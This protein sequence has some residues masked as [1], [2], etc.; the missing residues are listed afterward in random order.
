VIA[1][2]WVCFGCAAVPALLYL[3]NSL[4]FREP[5][6]IEGS[7][8][9]PNPQWV[10][11]SPPSPLSPRER[12]SK[13]L[14]LLPQGEGVGGEGKVGVEG[15]V[16]VLIPARNEE[17][18][19][20][21]CVEAVLATQAVEIEVI[22]LDDHSSDRTAEVVRGIAARDPRVRLDSAPPLPDGWSGKQHACFVLSKLARY[23]HFAFLD[24]DVRLK[25]DALARMM[26]FL[27]QSQA[28]LVSGF[29]FQETGSFLEKMLI[30]LINWLLLSFL[31]IFFMRYFR[32]AGFGAGCG[33]LFVSSRSAYQKAGGHQAIKSSRHD[34]LMLPR[35]Y[36]RTGFMTD[37]CDAGSIATCRMYRSFHTV[38]FG[39]AKNAREG[40]A[41]TRQIGFWTM[42]LTCGQVL[43][44]GLAIS[45]Y[46]LD[47]EA[48]L[49]F[50]AA[51]MLSF[52][53]RLHLAA[54]SD[55]SIQ[56][57]LLHPLAILLLLAVQW[58]AIGRAIL[59]MPVGWKG[60]EKPALAERI[61]V[62]T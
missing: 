30:P 27:N 45:S 16:S 40:M 33:Q 24:A 37:I 7:A 13:S 3:W 47:S 32:M 4:L 9:T 10:P 5:P 2:A 36:R 12:G 46:L 28:D 6:A 61:S 21:A 56:G 17:K 23:D 18:S 38:W 51:A 35:A 26:R 1:F 52:V 22:V 42:V 44:L 25:P 57:S 62:P 58:Y 14:P 49:I 48:W 15:K 43:P 34:G 60:R 8:L 59:G 31:P 11:P 54:R 50:A 55:Q 29:P 41:A 19:I 20:A 53:A 39:L